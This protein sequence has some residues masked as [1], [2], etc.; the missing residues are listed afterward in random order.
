MKTTVKWKG[1][2]LF[3]GT[4]ESGHDILMDGPAQYGGQD[5]GPRPMDLLLLGLGGCT[6][7]DV[8]SILEKKRLDLTGLEVDLEADR[9]DTHP[10][11]YSE[12]RIHFKI[13]GRNI[14]EKAVQQA[15]DLSENKFCSASAMLKKT[16]K[17]NISYEIHNNE[18]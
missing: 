1:M 10:K 7:Y 8:V 6:A 13:Q 12:I 15:I 14:P 16:A 3:Q 5:A 2:R 9:T 4:A 18:R 17:I 11:V